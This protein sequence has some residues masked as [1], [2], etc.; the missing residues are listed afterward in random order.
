MRLFGGPQRDK[1]PVGDEPPPW[2][3][4]L[5]AVGV[6]AG[7]LG[8]SLGGPLG[9]GCANLGCAATALGAFAFFG[10]LSAWLRSPR[11]KG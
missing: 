6:A 8:R 9:E 4:P 10:L 1:R 11:R 2:L 5:G 7:V 3:L